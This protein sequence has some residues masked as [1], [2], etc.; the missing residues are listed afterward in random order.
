M[1][2]GTISGVATAEAEM[3]GKGAADAATA[4]AE[5]VVASPK[6]S[7]SPSLSKLFSGNLLEKFTLDNSTYLQAQIRA[8]FYLKFENEKSDQEIRIRMIEM[9]AKGLATLEVCLL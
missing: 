4:G 6:T 9:V 2:E 1:M 7:G 3:A 5:A 8:T